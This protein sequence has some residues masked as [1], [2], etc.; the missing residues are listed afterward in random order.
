MYIC[1]HIQREIN[2]DIGI[3]IYITFEK[4]SLKETHTRHEMRPIK[5]TFICNSTKDGEITIWPS[6][7]DS[8]VIILVL[9]G[10]RSS[11]TDITE[12]NLISLLW[13][14]V[15]IQYEKCLNSYTN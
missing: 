2:I 6:A 8:I 9:A 13:A 4:I 1:I 10:S 11:F 5:G 15:E 14:L 12:Y 3:D 7:N